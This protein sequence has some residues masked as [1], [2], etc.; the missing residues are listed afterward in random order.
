VVQVQRADGGAGD[1]DLRTTRVDDAVRTAAEVAVWALASERPAHRWAVVDRGG[2]ALACSLGEPEG[3]A[4]AGASL[5][6]LQLEGEGGWLSIVTASSPSGIEEADRLAA[7]SVA[8]LL[9]AVIVTDAQRRRAEADAEEAWTVANIDPVADVLNARGLWER[10]SR[11]RWGTPAV[12]DV[13]VVRVAVDDLKEL[14]LRH[15]HLLGDQVLRSLAARL[16]AAVRS[17]DVVARLGGGAF[18]VVALGSDPELLRR[19]LGRELAE[20]GV[21]VHLGVARHE[22]GEPIRTTVARAD[23]D[24]RRHQAAGPG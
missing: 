15:G 18:V 20:V 21:G 8:R 1:V 17:G 12:A 24:L 16:S 6:D 10:L 3:W 4:S 9:H 11:I 5:A 22:P 14:N 7:R 2:H 19:R 13:N 23:L